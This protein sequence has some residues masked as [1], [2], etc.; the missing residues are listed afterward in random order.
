[1]IKDSADDDLEAQIRRSFQLIFNRDPDD[2]ELAASIEVVK[3]SDLSLVCR[4]LI[5]SNEFAFLP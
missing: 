5:N 3:E 1:S 2:E 4:S